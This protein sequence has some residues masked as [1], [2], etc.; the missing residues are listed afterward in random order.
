M[1]ENGAEFRNSQDI[2]K[3]D[4]H[5]GQPSCKCWEA[6]EVIHSK[7]MPHDTTIN[8][9]TQCDMQQQLH[10]LLNETQTSVTRL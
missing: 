1:S 6:E 7:I 2:H 3:N 10:R 4:K 8:V 9:D 5:N